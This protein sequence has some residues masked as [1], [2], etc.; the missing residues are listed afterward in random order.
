MSILGK[1]K[2]TR[3]QRK[4]DAIQRKED[5]V[6]VLEEQL[7]TPTETTGQGWN[8]VKGYSP[9]R[10]RLAIKNKTKAINRKKRK[11]GIV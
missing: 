2:K 1:G 8:P 9:A 4:L 10:V 11:L 3:E 7:K 6:K 5:K